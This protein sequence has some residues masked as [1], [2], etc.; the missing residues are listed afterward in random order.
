MVILKSSHYDEIVAYCESSPDRE[1]CGIITGVG[2][3]AQRVHRLD[4]VAAGREAVHYVADPQQ[5]FNVVGKT[6][7]FDKNAGIDLVAVYHSHPAG[8]PIPSVIDKA[9]AGYAVVYIVYSG[10][11]RAMKAWRWDGRRFV[12]EPLVVAQNSVRPRREADQP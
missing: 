5:F 1:V 4:N 2:D 7:I 10:L 3:R 11:T 6:R 8:R 9:Q 12:I